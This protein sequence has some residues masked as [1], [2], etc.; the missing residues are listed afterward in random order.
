MGWDTVRTAGAI[1]SQNIVVRSLGGEALCDDSNNSCEGDYCSNG[2]SYPFAKHCHPLE[3]PGYSF[4]E[5]FVIR[6]NGSS[7]LFRGTKCHLSTKLFNCSNKLIC[8]TRKC[9]FHKQTTFLCPRFV[10]SGFSP[11]ERNTLYHLLWA[12][13]NN[14]GVW[15]KEYKASLVL[16]QT[17]N[18][19]KWESKHCVVS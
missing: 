1:R 11:L 6:L 14:F 15:L 10:E 8:P 7:S 17:Q 9:L 2:S 3:W 4:K 16:L 13:K 18:L 5:N 19:A 12:T